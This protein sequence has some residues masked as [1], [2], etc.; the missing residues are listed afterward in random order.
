MAY[1]RDRPATSEPIK[2]GWPVLITNQAAIEAA[3]DE[4]HVF[5]T[6]G[7]QTGKHNKVALTDV[8]GDEAGAAGVLTIWNDAGTPKYRQTTGTV[9]KIS[10][11]GD[12]IP[13]GTKMW[14]YA[15][16][17]P[18]GWTI[19]GTPSDELLGIKGGATYTTGGVQAGTWTQPDHLHTTPDH[20]LVTSEMPAHVHAMSTWTS[21]GVGDRV[22]NGTINAGNAID[23]GSTGGD[24]VH[25]H[26]NTGN[27]ATAN[28]WRPLARVGI[29]CTKDAY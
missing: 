22:Q 19:D 6:G 17:A 4:D 29:I 23:T 1:D 20:Q 12:T 16:T 25:N 3:L 18:T 5:T 7:S 13:A 8:A 15:D 21:A 9:R 10:A 11:D 27:S 26:G 28:T 24:G 14:F 2:T